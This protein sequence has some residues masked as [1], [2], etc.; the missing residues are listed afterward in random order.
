M[1]VYKTCS[2]TDYEILSPT[3]A[4]VVVAHTGEPTR[5][6][7]AQMLAAKMDYLAAPVRGSF[8]NIRPGLAVGFVRA[9]KEIRLLEDKSQYRVMSSNI[10]MDNTDK[11]LWDVKS[12]AG[13]KYLARHGQEDLSELVNASVY[14]RPDLPGLRHVTIAKAAPQEMVAFVDHDG[15]M[16]Y[17]YAIGT[18]EAQVRV[19]SNARRIPVTVDYTRVV[20]ITAAPVPKSTHVS[21]VAQLS[22]AQ[23][24]ADA[25]DYYRQ[26]YGFDPAYLAEVI[27]SIDGSSFA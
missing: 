10:L 23:A 21:V 12:G 4:K 3:L 11:T 8:R 5:D 27:D 14:R 9:N 18:S 22:D 24:K 17:G 2:V 7:V 15:S 20:S 13:G 6:E 1:Q 26:L 16:D 25:K 19:F